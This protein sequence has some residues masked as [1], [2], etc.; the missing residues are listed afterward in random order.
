MLAARGQGN[1]GW[2]MAETLNRVFYTEAT[3]FGKPRDGKVMQISILDIICYVQPR[4][5][6]QPKDPE[7]KWSIYG[8]EY[9]GKLRYDGN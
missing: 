4:M 7:D 2:G 9:L 6:H 5:P 8:G 3:Q 1:K